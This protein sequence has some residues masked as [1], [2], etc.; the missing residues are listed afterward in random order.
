MNM[1]LLLYGTSACH[2][3]EQAEVLLQSLDLSWDK[4]DIADDKQLM[5]SYELK[6]PV[7]YQPDT[8]A[9]LCWPFSGADILGWLEN[10]KS[11]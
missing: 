3:C 11:R 7:L 10:A 9:K 2:L 5:H 1:K 8:H 6:I 4:I